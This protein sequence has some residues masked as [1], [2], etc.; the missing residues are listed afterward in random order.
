MYGCRLLSSC[1]LALL[2]GSIFW[3]LGSK[4]SAPSAQKNPEGLLSVA[5]SQPNKNRP[6]LLPQLDVWECRDN[7]LEIQNVIVSPPTVCKLCAL[8]SSMPSTSL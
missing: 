5:E 3:D 1:F 2:F 4:R 6:L 8:H 7:A